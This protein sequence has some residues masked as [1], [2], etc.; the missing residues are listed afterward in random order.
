MNVQNTSHAGLQSL[1]TTERVLADKKA[2]STICL[3][4]KKRTALAQ[5]ICRL[6]THISLYPNCLTATL[7]GWVQS[8]FVRVSAMHADS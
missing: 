4:F 2:T 6:A 3:V 7:S 5:W 1:L 8:R